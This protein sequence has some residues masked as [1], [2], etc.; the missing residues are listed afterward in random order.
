MVLIEADL[1]KRAGADYR[2]TTF[3]IPV[4]MILPKVNNLKLSEVFSFLTT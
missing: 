3:N 1:P 4:E 2:K